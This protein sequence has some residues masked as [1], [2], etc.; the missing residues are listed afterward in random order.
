M[1]SPRP[2]PTKGMTL[3]ELVVVIAISGILASAFVAMFV[4]MINFYFHYPQSSRL[5]DAAADLVQII[6]EGDEKAKGLRF[7]GLPCEIPTGGSNSITAASATS[8]TYQY[9]LADNCGSSGANDVTVTITYNSGSSSVTRA[10]DGGAA[11]NIPYYASSAAGISFASPTSPSAVNFFTY[12]DAAGADLGATPSVT[13]IY[14]VDVNVVA[15]YGS[16]DP[17]Y[18]GAQSRLKSGVEIKRYTT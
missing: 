8:L 15:S 2:G 12:Y 9:Q 16:G 7:A 4:P 17:E 5:N 13:A 3:V 18:A 10:I 6:L 14:R 1:R 11:A